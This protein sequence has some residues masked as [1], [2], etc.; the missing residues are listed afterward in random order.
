MA[1]PRKL[2]EEVIHKILAG[3]DGLEILKSV[4][5]RP[6]GKDPLPPSI[7]GRDDYSEAALRHRRELLAGQGIELP[8]LAGGGTDLPV[9][10]LQGN[11]EN[12][13]GYTKIP[14]GVIGPLRILG[15]AANGDFYIPLA[16]TEGALVA[17]YNRGARVLSEA[18]GTSVACLTES[19]SR[20]PCF[21]F[22]NIREVGIFVAWVLTKYDD[23]QEVVKRTSSHCKLQDMSTSIVGKELY[24]SLEFSTGDAS[25]QNM[26]TIATEAI[27]RTLLDGAPV[28][29]R[30]WYVEGNL[31]GD[32]KATSLS[33]TS[34]RGKKVVAEAAIP[35]EAVAKFLHTEP[36]ELV[37]YWEIS[38]LGGIQSAS[39]GV[40]GHYA[41]ALAALFIACGQDAACVS[42]AS[43]GLT[44]MECTDEGDLYVSVTL[45][46][47]IVGTVGGGTRFPTA[48]DCL[49]MLGCEG[50]GKAR[51]FAEICAATTLAGEISIVGALAAGQF[52]SA[53]ATHGRKKQ[54]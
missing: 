45:P 53:H 36:R 51:K 31:S 34:V 33:F 24:L 39:I 2:S 52:S 37:R 26:V 43:V 42:E 22:R 44:R 32:K 19:V 6:P 15:T 25:G 28:Q 1:A 20:A 29:P 30:R 17:S 8:H 47:L 13:I 12:F 10:D 9:E 5:P 54:G 16:T 18:G 35:K 50:Q 46:N 27:C 14:V 40:Q 11:I 4:E 41:N 21:M 49:K 38:I 23:L 7:P 3:R 48:R